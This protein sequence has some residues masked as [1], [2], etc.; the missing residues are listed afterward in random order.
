MPPQFLHLCLLAEKDVQGWGSVYLPSLLHHPSLPCLH[1]FWC[2]IDPYMFPFLVNLRAKMCSSQSR[3]SFY[4]SHSSAALVIPIE[5]FSCAISTCDKWP[6]I[7]LPMTASLYSFTYIKTS[8]CFRVYPMYQHNT[9][10]KSAC[11]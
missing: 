6:C 2:A 9:V 5:F 10:R 11:F 7:Q 8:R 1:T 3:H 4:T